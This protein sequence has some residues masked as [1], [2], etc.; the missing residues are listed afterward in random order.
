MSK[1]N[2]L[3]TQIPIKDKSGNVVGHKEVALYAGLLAKAHNE[4]L[5]GIRTELVQVPSESNEHTAIVSA[6][7]ETGKGVFCGIGDAHEGNVNHRILPHIIRMAETRAK[8]GRAAEY[9]A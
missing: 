7:V 9:T 3:T 1:D 6:Q 8:A 2:G 5:K 4:G